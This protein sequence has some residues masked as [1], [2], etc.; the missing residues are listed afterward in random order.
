MNSA[1]LMLKTKHV[2]GAGAFCCPFLSWQ[3]TPP[4]KWAS[5]H[6]RRKSLIDSSTENIRLTGVLVISGTT[7]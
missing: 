7:G 3:K 5:S 2:S 6:R 1:F 4:G